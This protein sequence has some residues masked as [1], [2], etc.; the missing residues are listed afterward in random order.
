MFVGT[1]HIFSRL[2][3]ATGISPASV[4]NALV[5]LEKLGIVKEL[6]AQKRN[7]VF[8]YTEY[9]KIMNRG[10]ELPE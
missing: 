6:T 3:K 9:V 2:V 8:G 7:R 10:T 1:S 4:N 5:N